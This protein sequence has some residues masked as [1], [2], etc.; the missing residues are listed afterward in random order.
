[1]DFE[2]TAKAYKS[3]QNALQEVLVSHK[4]HFIQKY[5]NAPGHWDYLFC[6]KICGSESNFVQEE[7]PEK[8]PSACTFT[9]A[10]KSL[11]DSIFKKF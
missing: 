9:C 10:R 2:S 1:M 11:L 3:H 8:C 4:G 6:R 5:W 7:A